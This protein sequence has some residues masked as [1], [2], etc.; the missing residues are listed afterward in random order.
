MMSKVRSTL[1][2]VS[3]VAIAASGLFASPAMAGKKS[4]HHSS[5]KKIVQIS[6]GGNARTGNGGNGGEGGD[7]GSAVNTGGS[8]TVSTVTPG[9]SGGQIACVTGIVNGLAGNVQTAP[10][11][12]SVAAAVAPCFPGGATPAGLADCLFNALT[13]TPVT[14][15]RT[16]DIVFFAVVVSFPA[17]GACIEAVPSVT[18]TSPGGGGA[19]SSGGAGGAGA[20]SGNAQGGNAG[21]NTISDGSIHVSTNH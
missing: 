1:V 5:S 17:V 18:T 15:P 16:G 3:V 7:G 6:K 12:A 19:V 13:I 11:A 14:D 21:N 20:A 10:T 4:R 2:A 9:I 8:S